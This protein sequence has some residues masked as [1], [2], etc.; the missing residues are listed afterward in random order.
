[1]TDT[2]TQTIQ[3][4]ETVEVELHECPFCEQ[5][6]EESEMAEIGIDRREV[7]GTETRYHHK[8]SLCINCAESI[9]G[10]ERPSSSYNWTHI[11]GSPPTVTGLLMRGFV[12]GFA[13]GLAVGIPTLVYAVAGVLPALVAAGI[14]IGFVWGWWE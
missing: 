1:M 4:L 6:Y 5:H 3:R 8:A 13:I 11:P 10:Y 9:F 12:P 7:A 14:P 2:E